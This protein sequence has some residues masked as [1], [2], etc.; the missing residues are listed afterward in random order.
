MC[1]HANL[2]VTWRGV[3]PVWS[4]SLFNL[5]QSRS[6]SGGLP[7]FAEFCRRGTDGTPEVFTMLSAGVA[8]ISWL[9]RGIIVLPPLNTSSPR[10][11]I[12]D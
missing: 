12:V 2:H 7:S 11:F 5:S 1:L 3:R 8:Y 6:H 10:K 9:N 4:Q